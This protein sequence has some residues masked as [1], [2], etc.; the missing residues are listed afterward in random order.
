MPFYRLAGIYAPANAEFT[1]PSFMIEEG[2]ER[3]LW[4]NAA[5]KW[6]SGRAPGDSC[7]EGCQ[8]YI[9]VEMRDATGHA[10]VGGRARNKCVILDMDGPRLPLRWIG[11][12]KAVEVGTRVTL[13]IFFRDATIFAVGS[14]AN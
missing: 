14:G 7:D 11:V 9:M 2:T 13:R 3:G 5:A 12:D 6:M 8:A 4:L 1:T 10:V